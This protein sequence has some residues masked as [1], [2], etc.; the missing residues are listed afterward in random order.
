MAALLHDWAGPNLPLATALGVAEPIV[1]GLIARLTGSGT[2]APAAAL[3]RH[4]DPLTGRELEELP[5]L[6]AGYRNRVIARR[7]FLSELTVK[8]HLPRIQC[9]AG[10]AKPH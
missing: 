4:P 1:A 8:S 7:L 2:T 3:P 5:M 10:R 9:Q 6:S